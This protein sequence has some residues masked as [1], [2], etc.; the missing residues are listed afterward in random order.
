[1]F[2]GRGWCHRTYSAPLIAHLSARCQQLFGEVEENFWAPADVPSDE[3]LW[4]E[5]L[6]SQST[7]ESGPFSLQG[8]IDDGPDPEDEVLQPGQMDPEVEDEAYQSDVEAQD[9]VLDAALT[10]ITVT[11]DETSTA[12]PP[13]FVSNCVSARIK[14]NAQVA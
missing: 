6:F 9:D 12:H 10:H 2:G 13:A 4:L 7:G 5:Y 11:S 3:L 1:M 8:I 14:Y